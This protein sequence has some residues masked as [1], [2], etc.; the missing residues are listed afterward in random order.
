MDPVQREREL[1]KMQMPKTRILVTTSKADYVDHTGIAVYNPPIRQAQEDPSLITGHNWDNLKVSGIENKT[2]TWPRS[3]DW[4]E[5]YAQFIRRN[6]WCNEE[7]YEL[8]FLSPPVDF[9]VLKDYLK[10]LRKTVYMYDYSRNDF[11]SLVSRR[12]VKDIKRFTSKD[13]DY[14]TTY[15]CSYNRLQ[16]MEPFKSVLYPE[17]QLKDPTLDRIAKDLR[18]LF[19]KYNMTTYFDT[20]C[21]PALLKA[22]N[23]IM[24]LAPIDRYQYRKY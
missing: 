8:L 19:T 2:K 23:G 10:D 20:L 14:L 5:D 4:R 15:G 7:I 9:Q 3:M 13:G 6:K 1:I 16:E 22:K 24:P 21:V 17:H 12:R 11:V 18:K